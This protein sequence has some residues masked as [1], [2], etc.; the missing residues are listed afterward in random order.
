MRNTQTADRHTNTANTP[1]RT[2][3]QQYRAIGISAVAAAARY[4]NDKRRPVET[5]R[6]TR[7]QE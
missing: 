4:P 5:P 3:D 6:Y 1:G 2:L 7:E